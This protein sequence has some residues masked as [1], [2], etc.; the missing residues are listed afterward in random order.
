M[1]DKLWVQL[2]DV[3][4]DEVT[5]VCSHLDTCWP[6]SNDDKAEHSVSLFRCG[7]WQ[8]SL[9]EDVADLVADVPSILHFLELERMLRHPW[10]IE[11][12]RHCS[13]R[14]DEDVIV[15]FKR[16]L[17]LHS[18]LWKA[19]VEHAVSLLLEPCAPTADLLRGRVHMLALGFQEVSL[20]CD[21]LAD[22]RHNGALFDRAHGGGGQQRRVEEVV[23]WGD[24]RDVV[25][26][27]LLHGKAIHEADAAPAGAKHHHLRLLP[28]GVLHR[29][30]LDLCQLPFGLCHMLALLPWAE[31]RAHSG[32]CCQGNSCAL[33]S[34]GCRWL[35]SL[36]ST[37]AGHAMCG[38]QGS[39]RRI[40]SLGTR[41]GCGGC[42]SQQRE[43]RLRGGSHC[44]SGNGA[45][46]ENRSRR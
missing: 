44:Q 18:P 39:R 43:A 17:A 23:P 30:H 46:T 15:K 8:C 21:D 5:Q 38:S 6:T 4:A 20:P 2:A 28:T 33:C 37:V 14:V 1:I 22:G 45:W 41:P 34:V 25:H 16:K 10:A 35:E 42:E 32:Q 12:V 27:R 29:S 36:R 11:V 13:D 9:L 24:H 7:H 19:V 3:I 26:L 31:G 40:H